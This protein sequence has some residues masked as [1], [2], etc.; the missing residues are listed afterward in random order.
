MNGLAHAQ[1]LLTDHDKLVEK[2][3]EVD[4][5]SAHLTFRRF[6]KAVHDATDRP[7][8]FY[9]L[10]R[11]PNRQVM[12]HYNWLIEIF[13]RS[14]AFYDG[15]PPEIKAMSESIRNADNSDPATVIA[16][17]KQHAGLFLNVQSNYVVPGPRRDLSDDE[18]RHLLRP[19]VHIATQDGLPQLVRKMTGED[20]LEGTRVNSSS[21]H[22]DPAVFDSPE[23]LA[24]LEKRNARDDQLYRIVAEAEA[25]GTRIAPQK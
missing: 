15:H 18:L 8:R 19:Y 23:I 10:I 25:S 24:F 22:F 9:T 11:R 6:R 3:E 12:S 4:Y 17:L 16:L 13:H 14:P 2:I 1:S 5:L 7:R 21:Y 20:F